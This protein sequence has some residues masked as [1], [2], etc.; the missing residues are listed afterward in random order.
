MRVDVLVLG[1]GIVGTALALSLAMKGRSVAMIEKGTG[2]ATSF[3][4]AGLIQSE[5]VMPYPFPR[6]PFLLVQYALNQGGSAL[7]PEGCAACR[8]LSLALFPRFHA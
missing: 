2:G 5:A 6:D 1:G 3:G 7:P 8:A 4:N